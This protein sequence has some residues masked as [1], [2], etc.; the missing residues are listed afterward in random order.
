[1]N[2]LNW[3]VVIQIVAVIGTAGS[4]YAAIRSDLVRMHEKI[5]AMNDR[6]TRAEAVADSRLRRV[7]DDVKE[8][9]KGG[10]Q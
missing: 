4:V 1:M 8:I 7:E 3:A 9:F 10:A 6:V 2:E 5:A